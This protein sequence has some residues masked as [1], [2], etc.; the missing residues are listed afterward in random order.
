LPT[1][2]Q[3]KEDVYRVLKHMKGSMGFE[4]YDDVIRML[5][6]AKKIA[7]EDYFGRYPRLKTFAREELDRFD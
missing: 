1:T 4:T 3:V 7:A 6:K 5:L 2:I